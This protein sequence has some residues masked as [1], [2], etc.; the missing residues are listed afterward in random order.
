MSTKLT[1]EYLQQVAKAARD[2]VSADRTA[3]R[4]RLTFGEVVEARPAGTTFRE[5]A[6]AL[7]VKGRTRQG[8]SPGELSKAAMV[9]REYVSEGGADPKDLVDWGFD[10]LWAWRPSFT[11]LS[12][13][14]ILA[15]KRVARPTVED[16]AEDSVLVRKA[17]KATPKASAGSKAPKEPAKGQETPKESETPQRPA[18]ASNR[19]SPRSGAASR[20][21]ERAKA[22][23]SGQASVGPKVQ[24]APKPAPAPSPKD[25]EEASSEGVSVEL[26]LALYSELRSLRQGAEGVVDVIRRLAREERKRQGVPAKARQR[27]SAR[28]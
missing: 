12:V 1:K 28:A 13:A 18:S 19:T 5:L 7:K 4:R 21:E 6:E 8:C 10:T 23:E 16:A 9:Y 11:G 3:T 27:P 17:A 20:S 15:E 14:E 22:R 2:V 26:P 24:E 25:S